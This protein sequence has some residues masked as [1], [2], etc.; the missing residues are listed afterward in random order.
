M[1][2]GMFRGAKRKKNP[3]YYPRT[4]TYIYIYDWK[5]WREKNFRVHDRRAK[6]A[7]EKQNEAKSGN[8]S[9]SRI[10]TPNIKAF[11]FEANDESR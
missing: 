3:H 6:D 5:A 10:R 1:T 8:F 11:G 9:N 2:N 7:K 4:Y